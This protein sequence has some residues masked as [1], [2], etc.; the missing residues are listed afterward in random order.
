MYVWFM[1]LTLPK[2]YRH[3]ELYVSKCNNLAAYLYEIWITLHYLHLFDMNLL[4]H[5]R[6]CFSQNNF[7]TMILS[8]L[9]VYCLSYLL[10]SSVRM[11]VRIFRIY[12]EPWAKIKSAMVLIGSRSIYRL[13]PNIFNFIAS[14]LICETVAD[15]SFANRLSEHAVQ[16]KRFQ[17]GQSYHYLFKSPNIAEIMLQVSLKCIHTL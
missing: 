2:I 1:F 4:V 5:P 12:R 16:C 11:T 10:F 15:L 13:W 14:P 17:R 8:Q 9:H 3:L 7:T 6:V